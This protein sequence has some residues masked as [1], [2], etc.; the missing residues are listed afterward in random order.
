MSLGRIPRIPEIDSKNVGFCTEKK[1]ETMDSPDPTNSTILCV[2]ALTAQVASLFSA[3]LN[4][5]VVRM[6]WWRL[7]TKLEMVEVVV[8]R[9]P[10]CADDKRSE[11]SSMFVKFKRVATL[12]FRLF[13]GILYNVWKR[14]F[15]KSPIV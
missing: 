4:P 11:N 6:R 8:A 15:V 10:K 7:H 3:Q 13:V 9:V 12:P 1:C 2:E 5:L 14:F